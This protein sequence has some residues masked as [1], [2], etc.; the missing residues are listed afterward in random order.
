MEYFTQKIN[1]AGYGTGAN[2]G[3]F[4]KWGKLRFLSG[5]LINQPAVS[6]VECRKRHPVC[7]LRGGARTRKTNRKNA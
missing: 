6:G 4:K 2:Y 7:Y 5:R 3:P 1:F